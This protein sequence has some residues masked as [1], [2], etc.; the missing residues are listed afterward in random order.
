MDV[1]S[2]AAA[3]PLAA[4][5]LA[6]TLYA[7]V[8]QGLLPGELAFARWLQDTPGGD[9]FEKLAAW[10]HALRYPLLVAGA[11]FALR[12][13]RMDLVAAA[14]LVVLALALNPL[15]K[16]LVSRERPLPTELTLRE[17]AGSN[18]Y[19]SG[20]VHSVVLLF[21]YAAVVAAAGL[22]R[23]WSALAAVLCVA[24]I[25]FVGW[26]RVYDGAHWPSDVIGS[27]A[28]GGAVLFAT[29]AVAP[30]LVSL[31]PA[32]APSSASRA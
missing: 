19:P 11:L 8:S 18:G 22:P 23:A 13:R 26:E 31:G 10:T 15:L 5:G 20:H 1:R 32:S 4:A 2:A 24:A 6:L 29:V 28:I 12:L 16:E 17:F 27:V 30:A 9:T 3:L 25:A 7:A 21:G 14:A